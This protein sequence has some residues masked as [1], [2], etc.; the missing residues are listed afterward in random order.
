MYIVTQNGIFD[1]DL[2]L[3][4]Q[5]LAVVDQQFDKFEDEFQWS[6][7][8]DAFGAYDWAEHIAGIGFAACQ[9]YIAATY[10]L[11]H[12]IKGDALRVGPLHS[13]SGRPVAAILNAAA[14]FWKHNPEWPLEKN[15][16]RQD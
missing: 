2:D 11:T 10:P 6:E 12:V 13:S 16:A 8:A 4:S 7:E 3:L 15:H 14:N 9:T 5:L 1:H